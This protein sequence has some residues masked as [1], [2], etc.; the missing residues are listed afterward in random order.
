MKMTRIGVIGCGNIS[1]IYFQNISRFNN[2]EVTAIAD[3]L[4]ERAE[5]KAKTYGGRAMSV[6]ELLN[7]PEVDVVLNLTIPAA[8]YEIDMKALGAGKH[9]YSEKPLAT[10]L[11]DGKEIIELAKSKGLFVGCAPDTFMGARP[12]TMKKMIDEG[13]IGRP[14]AATAFM[15]CPGHECWHPNPEFYYKFGAGPLFDMGP[16]YF[17]SL[18]AMLGPAK[19]ICGFATKGYEKRMI[20]SEPL[21]GQMIDVDVPTHVAGTIEFEKGAV[22]TVIMSFDVWD[23][24]LPCLEIYGTEG[25]IS[26]TDPDPLAGPDIFHGTTMFRR[27]N[28]SDWTGYPYSLP[29]KEERTPWARI[30]SCYD[31]DENSRALGLADMARAIKNGGKYR[32]NGDFAYHVLEIMHGFYQA[33]ETGRYYEMTS[34]CEISDMMPMNRPE[35]TME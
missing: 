34:T 14:I 5:E 19:R 32:A 35:F 3:M 20:T 7:C 26:M 21:A 9:V 23:H 13:W 15:V 4:P 6:D 11:E 2:I 31:Y 24:N 33:A 16:Y 8:H 12:Q 25:T 28:E 17:A 18:V 22:A 1:D 10:R 27:K 30:P 29:R